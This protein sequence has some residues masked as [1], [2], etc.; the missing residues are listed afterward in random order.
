MCNVRWRRIISSTFS[1]ERV[2]QMTKRVRMLLR[3]SS[4][5]QLE[6]DGDLSVQR[7]LVIEYIEKQSDWV[8]DAKEYFEGSNSGYK[9]AVADRDVLQEALQDAEAGEYD[10]LVAYKDDR[11]GRR[12][13]EIG[14]YVMTLKNHGVDIYTVKDGCISPESD[15]IMGQMMLALRYGNAQKSSSDTGM[16]V[17]DTAQKLVQKGRFIGGAAPYGYRLELSGEISKHGRAL[18]HLVIVPEEAEVVKYIYDLSLNKEYGSTRIAKVLNQHEKYKQMAPRD[19][20]KSGTITSILTN[21]VYAGHIAYKRRERVNGKYHRLDSK[22]WITSFEANENIMIIDSDTWNRTQDRRKMRGDKYIKSLENK[23]VTVIRR[24]SGMLALIDVLYCGYCGSKMTNGSR[25]NYWTIKSTGERRASKI[26]I[27]KCQ[28]AWKGIPHDKTKQFRADLVEPIVFEAMAQYIGKL[29]ENEDVF[30]QIEEN[31]NKEKKCR[32]IELKR[33]KENFDKM[34]KQIIIMESKIPDAMTGDYPL[35][36]EELVDVIKK[37]KAEA[38]K[39]QEIVLQKEAEL[40]NASVSVKEWEELR[41]N[42][43]TWQEVFL[44]ADVPTKR[45]LVDKLVERIDIKKNE[46]IIR[47]KI[48]FNDFFT[49]PE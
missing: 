3:V 20:W 18:H 21:P 10:I 23:D 16:R 40:K 39:Q 9:N 14:A 37:R 48:N 26:A 43:P 5:Q 11:I 32:A 41:H 46:I 33:E 49:N 8:L 13:W 47:F 30:T 36:L 44:K 45:V 22:D 31:Q 38:D 12:M 17:K 4:N 29:Q 2:C 25:Y 7:Q 19:T 24:N 15:D 27:Y 28:T 35:S 1:E 34:Q 6:A 42:I